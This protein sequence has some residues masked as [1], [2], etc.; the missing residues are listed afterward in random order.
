MLKW[1]VDCSTRSCALEAGYFVSSLFLKGL[2]TALV[3]IP[4]KLHGR[5]IVG[6]N[7]Y[8]QPCAL[9]MFRLIYAMLCEGVYVMFCSDYLTSETKVTLTKR[10][11]GIYMSISRCLEICFRYISG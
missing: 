9:Q 11:V 3:I 8:F 7:Y 1:P 4:A 2:S 5:K 6:T 10:C